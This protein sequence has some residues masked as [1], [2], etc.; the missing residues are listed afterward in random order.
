[1][2]DLLIVDWR[3]LIAGA[4][5]DRQAMTPAMAYVWCVSGLLLVA[6]ARFDSGGAVVDDIT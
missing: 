2:I 4:G 5:P 3:C 6:G 1:M